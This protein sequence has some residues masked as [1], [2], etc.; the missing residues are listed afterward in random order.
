MSQPYF[1]WTSQPPELIRWRGGNYGTS[2]SKI[3]FINGVRVS[4][5]EGL[6]TELERLKTGD[7]VVLEVERQGRYQFVSFDME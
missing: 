7:P 5:K 6:R 3:R 2:C 4:S 1:F